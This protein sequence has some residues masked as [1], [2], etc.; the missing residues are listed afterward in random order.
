MVAKPG[1]SCTSDQQ[2][3]YHDRPGPTGRTVMAMPIFTTRTRPIQLSITPD[4]III[5]LFARN[6]NINNNHRVYIMAG[7][8]KKLN[9]HQAGGP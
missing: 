9:V 8:Q 4:I 1:S 2:T 5:N 6:Q 7:R 3:V